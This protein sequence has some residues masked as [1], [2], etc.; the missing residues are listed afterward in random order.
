[1]LSAA[2]K[3]QV[4]AAEFFEENASSIEERTGLELL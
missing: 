3:L 4:F 2:E 1:V